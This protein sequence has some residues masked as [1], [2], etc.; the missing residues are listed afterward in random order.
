MNRIYKSRGKS[1][2]EAF[3]KIWEIMKFHDDYCLKRDGDEWVIRL[4]VHPPSREVRR[5][6]EGL[7]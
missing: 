2:E 4:E 5:D 6:F 7:Q 1:A 3:A